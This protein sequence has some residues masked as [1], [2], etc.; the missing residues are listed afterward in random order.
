MMAKSQAE[1]ADGRSRYVDRQ[2]YLSEKK[3]GITSVKRLASIED[4]ADVCAK[5]ITCLITCALVMTKHERYEIGRVLHLVSGSAHQRHDISYEGGNWDPLG[6]GN[7]KYY[8]RM[9]NKII[10]E[11]MKTREFSFMTRWSRRIGGS[12][13]TMGRTRLES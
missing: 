10:A 7:E 12:S 9:K 5:R 3:Q 8:P 11:G 2:N 6:N 4:H 13:A 1:G